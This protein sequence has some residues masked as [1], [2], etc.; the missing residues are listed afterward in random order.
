[1]KNILLLLLLLFAATSCKNKE[2][3]EDDFC[4]KGNFSVKVV[5]NWEDPS[6]A[7]AMRMNLFSL[8]PGEP[9]F[10][11]DN[12][13]A[14]GEKTITLTYGS[15]HIP[16]CYDYNAAVDFRNE[17]ILESFQASCREATRSTYNSLAT[18]VS[19]EP[20][21]SDPGGAFFVHSWLDPFDVE[22]CTDCGTDDEIILNFYPK[23]K[24]YRFTYRINNVVGAEYLSSA[25]GAASG[26]AATYFFSTDQ[27]STDRTTVLFENATYGTDRN[28]VGYIEGSFYTFGPVAP[29]Q[30]RFTIEVLAGSTDYNTAYWDVSE[31]ITET[32]TNREAKLAR[33]GYDI[34]IQ[35]DP[36]TKL[37]E[38]KEPEGGGTS[39]SG[40]EIGVGEWDNVDIYL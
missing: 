21:V 37:P 26:M 10:G 32:M 5:V 4:L 17:I 6:S 3:S 16:L 19:G 14:A 31:Q 12:I 36:D 2:L 27:L 23:N 13:S 1:M 20:T 33:D 30:N 18:P 24:M 38:I 7:R 9:D 35:N 29:Y 39:G 28:G 34:L 22:L 15:S 8:T 40:F 11:R 25:R